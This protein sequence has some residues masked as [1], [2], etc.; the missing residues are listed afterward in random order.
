VA[1][2]LIIEDDELNREL[3]RNFLEM[4]GYEV[5]V[6]RDAEMGLR[7][8]AQI[9]PL[10]ILMDWRLPG[11]IDGL[12]ATRQLK[13]NPDLA[14]IPV[15]MTTAHH[16]PDGEQRVYEAG[17]QGFIPKPFDMRVLKDIVVEYAVG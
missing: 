7:L 4:I 3:F 12:N 9:A 10:L 14:H 8:A 1:T 15:I 17:C 5:H 16:F 13:A 11:T 6:A 2:I